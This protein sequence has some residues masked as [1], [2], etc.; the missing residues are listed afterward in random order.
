MSGRAGSEPRGR[1]SHP[2][3]ML[4]LSICPCPIRDAYSA[5]IMALR[6]VLDTLRKDIGVWLVSKQYIAKMLHMSH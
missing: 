5:K 3:A 1:F 2:S 6:T 4:T